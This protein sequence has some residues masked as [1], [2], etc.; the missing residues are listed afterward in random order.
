[1]IIALDNNINAAKCEDVPRLH[2]MGCLL[3]LC[4]QPPHAVSFIAVAR[5]P[6]R[7]GT[8]HSYIEIYQLFYL[9]A[10]CGNTASMKLLMNT[11]TGFEVNREDETGCSALNYAALGGH[12]EAIFFLLLHGAR[13]N[14]QELLNG[15]S[16]LHEA[17]VKGFSRS[18]E[19]LC[20]SRASPN[21]QNKLLFTPLHLAAQN[22]H[23]QTTRI[24][25]CFGADVNAKNKYGD[26]PLHTATRYGHTGVVRI[27][28]TVKASVTAINANYD[29]PLHIA[30]ALKRNVIVQLLSEAN[31]RQI[32]PVVQEAVES[33]TSAGLGSRVLSCVLG[34]SPG[35]AVAAASA[36]PPPPRSS[37]VLMR[38]R[39]NETPVDVA[40]RKGYSKIA[41]FL[42]VRA[43]EAL[44]RRRHEAYL[45]EVTTGGTVARDQSAAANH[46]MSASIC[47]PPVTERT[48]S[49][50][51]R[52]WHCAY[53]QVVQPIKKVMR[54]TAVSQTLPYA[55]PSVLETD[56]HHP[57]SN[58]HSL[59]GG[60]GPP[61]FSTTTALSQADE[62]ASLHTSPSQ[63]PTLIPQAHRRSIP[64]I[65]TETYQM[66]E[67][68]RLPA[69]VHTGEPPV[70]ITSRQLPARHR[71]VSGSVK[72]HQHP[73]GGPHF[74]LP[75]PE[76]QRSVG[77][78]A[79]DAVVPT[80][81]H[82]I[83]RGS[84]F[85]ELRQSLEAALLSS[86]TNTE[87][88]SCHSSA[89]EKSPLGEQSHVGVSYPS[90]DH[91]STLTEARSLLKSGASHGLQQAFLLGKKANEQMRP[92]SSVITTKVGEDSLA[93]RRC[94]PT[95]MHCP[96]HVNLTLDADADHPSSLPTSLLPR[97]RLAGVSEQDMSDY[98]DYVL[99]T[100]SMHSYPRNSSCARQVEPRRDSING[101]RTRGSLVWSCPVETNHRLLT[102]SCTTADAKR[103]ALWDPPPPPS[104]SLAAPPGTT[105]ARTRSDHMNHP[106]SMGTEASPL[107]PFETDFPIAG[108]SVT[109]SRPAAKFGDHITTRA[110]V[111]LP[112]IC[113]NGERLPV[114][115]DPNHHLKVT[116]GPVST[117]AHDMECA[118]RLARYTSSGHHQTSHQSA[119]SSTAVAVMP[120]RAPF[121]WR[122]LT[123]YLETMGAHDTR[124]TSGDQT[125]RP[126]R[127]T[128]AAASEITDD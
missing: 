74:D 106:A 85:S 33:D 121:K 35:R 49:R 62:C 51:E 38:N 39:Q 10:A 89:F 92:A 2:G 102:R 84:P 126:Q 94:P 97:T 19:A 41:K 103:S 20:L 42:T 9:A 21:L 54:Q 96:P 68:L 15:N 29:T 75:R 37:A 111:N 14:V 70:L 48:P 26:T 45:E 66:M 87:D 116:K 27:L 3:Q 123:D 50:L 61:F 24:L 23:K 118:R 30:A 59:A 11:M 79:D 112:D 98:D 71:L 88:L 12:T 113:S 105:V 78:G 109:V 56:S 7:G 40:W 55:L 104:S 107:A 81:A 13:P 44:V 115:S 46:P 25:L 32:T 99:Q 95:A 101:D 6:Q 86:H 22:G 43:K 60:I 53:P 57:V 90:D 18:V 83:D 80:A 67:P 1:M 8:S 76:R 31:K 117:T 63:Q 72:Q 128:A 127:R 122:S 17:A 77:V 114:D 36:R 4:T 5:S 119:L 64:V 120:E 16:P 58:T 69:S 82:V 52:S 28:L 100:T 65:K 110:L 125:S 108:S 73:T 91:M 93:L 47:Y 124:G 34:S